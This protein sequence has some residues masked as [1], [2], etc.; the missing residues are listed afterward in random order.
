MA[1]AI[2]RCILF[3]ASLQFGSL[4]LGKPDHKGAPSWHDRSSWIRRTLHSVT[5]RPKNTSPNLRWVN[6]NYSLGSH[7]WRRNA[8]L[9]RPIAAVISGASARHVRPKCRGYVAALC[10][11]RV[12]YLTSISDFPAV[13][14]HLGGVCDRLARQ[15]RADRDQPLDLAVV[16]RTPDD[17]A[18]PAA[19]SGVN[20]EAL[21]LYWL[22]VSGVAGL[23]ERERSSEDPG[24]PPRC[25][26]FVILWVGSRNFVIPEPC[27][28]TAPSAPSQ[29]GT[30]R[31]ADA[32][33][34]GVG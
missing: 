15:P 34:D 29:F 23:G 22:R 4:V 3:A 28:V 18:A 33:R 6:R 19:V 8:V 14:S 21:V 10:R 24:V 16:A 13:G 7:D 26:D 9:K 2:R 5:S 31:P 20:H 32:S 17:P 27:G 11:C 25:D 30:Q 12:T 1:R